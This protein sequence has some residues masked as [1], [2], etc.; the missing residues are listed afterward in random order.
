MLIIKIEK[1]NENVLNV[2]T[3]KRD[4]DGNDTQKYNE[5]VI[6]QI[7][8]FFSDCEYN[9]ITHGWRVWYSEINLANFQN[10]LTR[11]FPGNIKFVIRGKNDERSGI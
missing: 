2:N 6:K 11:K 8:Y 3:F 7:K 9:N 1:E 4:L 5:T 10:Y